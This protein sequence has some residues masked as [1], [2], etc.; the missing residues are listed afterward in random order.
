MEDVAE[1]GG[2]H[3]SLARYGTAA[4]HLGRFNGAYLV[5]RSLPESPWLCRDLLRWREEFAAPFWD[6]LVSG[7]EDARVRRGWPGNVADRA[8]R[9]WLERDSFLDAL[10]RLPRVLCHGDFERRNLFARADADGTT[11]T[12]AIDWA[13]AGP[14]AVGADLA[15]LVA[16]SVLWARDR[17]ATDLGALSRHC[18]EGYLAGLR[19]AGWAGETRLVRLGYTA[20]VALQFVAFAGAIKVG[21]AGDDERPRLEAWYGATLE[22]VLDRHAALQ[23]F[24]LDF[25]DGARSL[26]GVR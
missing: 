9:V 2:A 14:R 6:R 4:C 25:A 5:G 24:A 23:P 8:Y 20:T 13:Q 3:W 21:L 12:V 19:Q 10:D 18:Y 22:A 15:V 7:R 1:P 17:D 16:Q 26:L 11:E